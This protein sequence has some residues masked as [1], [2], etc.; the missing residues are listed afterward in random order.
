MAIFWCRRC[1]YWT[2]KRSFSERWQLR[3]VVSLFWHVHCSWFQ[4]LQN[5]SGI[6]DLLS[7]LSFWEAGAE[8]TFL[9]LPSFSLPVLMRPLFTSFI[10][11]WPKKSL[12]PRYSWDWSAVRSCDIS[13]HRLRSATRARDAQLPRVASLS[14]RSSISHDITWSDR[15]STSW[16]SRL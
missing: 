15:R 7:P 4:V 12:Q 16:I 2:W 11:P 6:Q 1:M 13:R 5:C 9:H 14:N 10:L 8:R 3:G